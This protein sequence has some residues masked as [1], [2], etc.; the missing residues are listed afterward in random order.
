MVKMNVLHGDESVETFILDHGTP[1]N[2]KVQRSAHSMECAFDPVNEVRVRGHARSRKLSETRYPP[3]ELLAALLG[4]ALVL[5]FLGIEGDIHRE[6][7]AFI[8]TA[9]NADPTI[10]LIDDLLHDR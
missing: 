7:C 4:V 6:T 3:S 10:M 1:K 9:L 8:R 5:S 2:C